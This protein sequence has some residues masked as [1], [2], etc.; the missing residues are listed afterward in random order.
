MTNQ[1]KLKE[2]ITYLDRFSEE[3][4]PNAEDIMIAYSVLKYYRGEYG[5][6]SFSNLDCS[7]ANLLR[8]LARKYLFIK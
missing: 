8:L 5:S 6:E 3:F 1:V 7:F 4:I 2:S